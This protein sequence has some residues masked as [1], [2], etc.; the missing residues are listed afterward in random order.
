MALG[1]AAAAASAKKTSVS[2]DNA[3]KLRHMK[4]VLHGF[5]YLVLALCVGAADALA[6]G[7]M[8][9]QMPGGIGGRP[10]AGQ[11]SPPTGDAPARAED[12]PDVAATKWFKAGVKSVHKAQEY[13]AA[14]AAAPNA[15]KKASALERAGDNYTRALDEFTEAL[16]N[17]GDMYEA[18]NYVGYVHLQLGA[19]AESIDDYNHAFALK[20]DNNLEAVES[21]A[22]AY[23]GADRLDDAKSAYM[24]LFSHQRTLA[25]QLMAAMQRWQSEHR[26]NANGMR[27]ADLDAFDKWL[28]DRDGIAKQTASAPH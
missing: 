1:W 5:G 13:V 23:L 7:Q 21:R 20:A 10:G 14:A 11:I 2:A 24:D 12:K 19:Y 28:Q 3:L 18:W 15:D 26:A 9:G 27:G 22:E 6:G 16:S 4:S 8:S 25:D 17:K